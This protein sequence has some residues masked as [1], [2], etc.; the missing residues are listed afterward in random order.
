MYFLTVNNFQECWWKTSRIDFPSLRV[1][2]DSGLERLA[3]QI[4]KAEQS[5]VP[6]MAVIGVKKRWKM[7]HWPFEVEVMKFFALSG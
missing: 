1:Q 5:R 3:K 2:V 6:I 4:R 7:R